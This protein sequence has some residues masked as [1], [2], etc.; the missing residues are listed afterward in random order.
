MGI[1]S[2]RC[3]TLLSRDIHPVS[4]NGFTLIELLVVVAIIAMMMAILIP[5][6][7][8]AR[9]QARSAKC[10]ANMQNMGIAVNTF[11]ATHRNY[12][13]IVTSPDRI[14]IFWGGR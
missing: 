11:A 13:Q 12:F 2:N 9:D 10:L 4:G 3:S 5:S 8:E 1:V 7:S 6:L 14:Q